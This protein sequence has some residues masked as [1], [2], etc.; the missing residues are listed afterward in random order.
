MWKTRFLPENSEKT[1]LE[2]PVEN[3]FFLHGLSTLS[4]LRE[5]THNLSTVVL[6]KSTRVCGFLRGS[7]P[8]T[9][10]KGIMPLTLYAKTS[11]LPGKFSFSAE[12]K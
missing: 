12:G 4:T 9:P 6:R 3:V 11:F 1:N 10:R 7:A 5:H 8:Q 2:N